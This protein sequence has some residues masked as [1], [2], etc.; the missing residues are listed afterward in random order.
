MAIGLSD[1]LVNSGKMQLVRISFSMTTGR[2]KTDS[3]A[4]DKTTSARPAERRFN[5]DCCTTTPTAH[6]IKPSRISVETLERVRGIE[7][8]YSAWKGFGG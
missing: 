2:R 3:K 7:P 5:S 1:I 8:S 6:R 4:V